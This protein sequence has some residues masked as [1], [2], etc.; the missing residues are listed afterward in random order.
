[1]RH[2]ESARC[3]HLIIVS[4]RRLWLLFAQ[5]VTVAVAALFVVQTLKPQWLQPAPAAPVVSAPVAPPAQVP[6]SAAQAPAHSYADAARRAAPAVVSV[7]ASK[8][9]RG[10][11][12]A[13]DPW[14][15]F[16]FGDGRATPS[17]QVGLGSGVIVSAHG[18]L[19]TNN[20]VIEG[21]DA[22]EVQLADGRQLRA[23][24]IGTDPETDLALLQ[25]DTRPA[26]G[27]HARRSA[28]DPRRRRGAGHR[29]PVQRRPDRDL[30]HRQRA[31]AQPARAVDLRELHP[32]RRGHQP[33]QF[34][35]RAGRCRAA[36]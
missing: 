33:G 4:M 29:Q 13:D 22:I 26:A 28:V 6:A 17:P 3:P 23:K 9:R 34:G 12:G 36:A 18:Y 7:V 11:A 10:R 1:M 25:I 27:D 2:C 30:G 35:R 24:L 21:A 14:L 32:D 5:A 19:L 20:H 8:A 31:R 16:F 15:R